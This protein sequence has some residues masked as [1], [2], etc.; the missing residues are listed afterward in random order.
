MKNTYVSLFKGYSDTEPVE[1]SLEKVVEIIQCDKAL[2]D[3]TEKHR[4]YLQQGLKRD[5]DREKSG[6]PC[7]GVAVR[8]A[9]G[10]MREHV[11]SWTGY[12]LVDL[13]HVEP[14]RMA[15]MLAQV[16]ADEH[17]LLAYTTISGR[18]IRIICC[19][20]DLNG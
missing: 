17:T 2:K 18:G 7:F 15:G 10:K 19:I 8:F 11:C 6:C 4:Y 3:R 1:T 20:E 12:T 13:D 9:G 16:C 5:A 14:D